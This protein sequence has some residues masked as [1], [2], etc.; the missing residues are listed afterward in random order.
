MDGHIKSS[1]LFNLA[2]LRAS[3]HHEP[4]WAHI[5]H[6]DRCHETFTEYVQQMIE[7]MECEALTQ[8]TA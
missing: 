7:E 8:R 6:C 5:E 1:R 3:V 2:E 4:E